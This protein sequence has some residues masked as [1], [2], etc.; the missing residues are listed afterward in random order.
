LDISIIEQ[1]QRPKSQ[2]LLQLSNIAV[3]T[4]N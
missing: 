1:T 2:K 3:S 4:S